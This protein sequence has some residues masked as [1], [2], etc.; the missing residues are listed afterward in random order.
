MSKRKTKGGEYVTPSPSHSLTPSPAR[1]EP[2]DTGNSASS[3][4]ME[5]PNPTATAAYRCGILA[6]IPGLGLVLGP[7]ALVWGLWAHHREKANPSERGTTQAIAAIVFG[8]LC[9]LTNWLGLYL[10]MLGL[11]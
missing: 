5:S 7:V 2:V 6:M 1:R 8:G 9:A 11:R 10:M 3:T 4:W